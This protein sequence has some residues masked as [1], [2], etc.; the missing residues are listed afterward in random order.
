MQTDK[1][2]GG[3]PFEDKIWAANVLPRTTYTYASTPVLSSTPMA[4]PLVA[5]KLLATQVVALPLCHNLG[6]LQVPLCAL[7]GR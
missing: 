4:R 3:N 1:N 2:V 7:A 6:L 5:H